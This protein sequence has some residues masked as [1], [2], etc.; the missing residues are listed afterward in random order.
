M[1]GFGTPK[2][3]TPCASLWP[4]VRPKA[5]LGPSVVVRLQVQVRCGKTRMSAVVRVPVL[6]LH[7]TVMEASL[8][9]QRMRSEPQWTERSVKRRI[10]WRIYLQ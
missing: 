9:R 5:L 8:A 2:K 1:D 3:N 7:S 6:S 10:T 4:S